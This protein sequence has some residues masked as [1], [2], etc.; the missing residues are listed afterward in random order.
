VALDA[1]LPELEVTHKDTFGHEAAEAAALAALAPD[2]FPLL[3]VD[4]PNF[5]RTT[6]PKRTFPDSDHVTLKGRVLFRAEPQYVAGRM[7]A[8]PKVTAV[9]FLT[10]AQAESARTQLAT[11]YDP[12]R[13][14]IFGR[15]ER[16][17]SALVGVFLEGHGWSL[18]G[19][20]VRV[21][22]GWSD[23]VRLHRVLTYVKGKRGFNEDEANTIDLEPSADLELR[24]VWVYEGYDEP[25]ALVEIQFATAELG[26]NAVEVAEYQLRKKVHELLA[27][28]LDGDTLC[29][30]ESLEKDAR[31]LLGDLEGLDRVP[32]GTALSWRDV[33]GTAIGHMGRTTAEGDVGVHVEVFSDDYII[34][35]ANAPRWPEV[36]EATGETPGTQPYFFAQQ[37]EITVND[38]LCA[39]TQRGKACEQDTRNAEEWTK[40]C[41]TYQRLLSRIVAYHINQWGIDWDRIK[42]ETDPGH[43]MGP[44]LAAIP[45]VE[46][47]PLDLAALGIPGLGAQSY[48]YYH[49]LRLVEWLTTGMD[50]AV[51]NLGEG[52][53]KQLRA[54]LDI[55]DEPMDLLQPVE[56]EPFFSLRVVVNDA[57]HRSGKLPGQKAVLLLDGLRTS[58]KHEQIAV[59]LKRGRIGQYSFTE[60][61]A[62]IALAQD[63]PGYGLPEELGHVRSEYG[64]EVHLLGDGNAKL[65]DSGV[66]CAVAA[67]T[68]RY[69]RARPAVALAALASDA[70]KIVKRRVIGAAA[71][72]PNSEFIVPPPEELGSTDEEVRYPMQSRTV[73]VITTVAPPRSTSASTTLEVKFIG[74]DLESDVSLQLTISTR[75]IAFAD[76]G[77]DVAKVQLYLSRIRIE[78][79]PCFVRLQNDKGKPIRERR[80]ISGVYE[81]GTAEAL[82]RFILYFSRT[83]EW[84]ASTVI[85]TSTGE[86]DVTPDDCTSVEE[87]TAELLAAGEYPVVTQEIIDELVEHYR[88]PWVPPSLVFGDPTR[89]LQGPGLP[90]AS[91]KKW[92]EWSPQQKTTL[93]PH[94]DAPSI[95]L[96][97]TL[98]EET[99]GTDAL[100]VEVV[101][102]EEEG[103]EI[104]EPVPHTVAELLGGITLRPSG[105][106]TPAKTK[107]RIE[108]YACHREIHLL[109]LEL[110]GVPNLRQSPVDGYAAAA[111]QDFMA[112][113]GAYKTTVDGEWGTKSKKAL[114]AM[115]AEYGC[116]KNAQYIELVTRIV[117]PESE[118]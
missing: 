38:K 88:L 9:A 117:E 19:D 103:Y 7:R 5:Y 112:A 35:P 21:A 30:L 2:L 104:A 62:T 68:A 77:E 85:T 52:A 81:E 43:S 63:E 15:V 98:L 1:D 56:G 87:K 13:V 39:G 55:D 58:P 90:L 37:K 54:Y 6:Q 89:Q 25:R 73:S 75:E 70:F 106:L 24:A 111:L 108:V 53:A 80:P 23:S 109:S 66:S 18:E 118:P 102:K 78:G 91:I 40:F 79:V 99:D 113:K 101:V 49:P 29:S 4:D 82:W 12:H 45:P 11:A 64:S 60:P 93:L 14:E 8:W 107:P 65:E 50:V 114:G 67:A 69:N 20:I 41:T 34:P 97:V 95:H 10:P 44:I 71:S 47:K 26:T 115:A 105:V 86:V 61:G 94:V 92:N 33:A 96:P 59:L 17:E 36:C 110:G 27:E 16:G 42:G 72:G 28:R 84:C 46:R 83:N 3:C 76:Q 57:T 31:A 100:R 22:D 32:E 74:G 116:T 48:Y 51:S